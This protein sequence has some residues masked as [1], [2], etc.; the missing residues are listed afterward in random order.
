MGRIETTGY[1]WDVSTELFIFQDNNA[2]P[3]VIGIAERSKKLIE[4]VISRIVPGK[5]VVLKPDDS[6]VRYQIGGEN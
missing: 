6:V 3:H 2:S 4:P 5:A 1:Q